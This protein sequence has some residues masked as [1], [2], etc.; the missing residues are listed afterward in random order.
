MKHNLA[1]GF[2]VALYLVAGLIALNHNLYVVAIIMLSIS[3]AC[4]FNLKNPTSVTH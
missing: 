2:F 1:K 3:V 4:V